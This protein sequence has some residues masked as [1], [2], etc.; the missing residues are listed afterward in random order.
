MKDC[1]HE[2]ANMKIW[3]T[4]IGEPL[5]VEKDVRLHRYG[6]ITKE[7]AVLGHDVI[8]WTSS[9]SHAPK[10]KVCHGNGDLVID[11]VTLR[12]LNGPGYKR[13]VSYQRIAHQR[14]FAK[15]F[16]RKAADCSMPDI[17]VSPVPTL[18]T[19]E[20]AVR[21]GAK[22]G[23]PVLV[24]I[25]DEWPD[26]FVN[27]APPSLRGLLR[28]IL[29][30]SFKRM[31]YICRNATGIIAMSMRQLDYGLSFAVR[32][33]GKFDGVFPLGYAEQKIDEE[34]LASAR[35]W[36]KEQGVDENAFICCF[37]GTIGR[38]FNLE[39]VIEAATILSKAFHIQVVL[40]GDGS[41]LARYKKLASGV[42]GVFFP[43]WM[44]APKIAALMEISH[45]GLAPYAEDTCMSLPN[46]PFEY[47]A[48]GL[49][50]VSSIQG[51]LKQILADND[52][53]RTYNADS[54]EELCHLLRSL[55]ADEALRSDMGKRARNLY[56]REFSLERIAK[57]LE[58][59]LVNVVATD[60]T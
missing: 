46:K 40:C 16:S 33:E 9:F 53:G 35:Q 13:N 24:D 34:K 58:G 51:E 39:T 18:E 5:P 48:G 60:G 6:M 1:S 47:F 14:D 3:F 42:K 25:R 50:V 59:H 8:W 31:S 43:G 54:V 37:F 36:W 56:E 20:A 45:V 28:L 15:Q 57:K 32:P 11:G 12:I 21:L 41:S 55:Y 23:T 7:L 17:I 26:E 44:D 27:L 2:F 49:P 29:H 4:E 30:G 10:K 22:H 52:C 19:A 38:F